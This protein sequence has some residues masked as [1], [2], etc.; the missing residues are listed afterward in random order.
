MPRLHIARISLL[1][2]L[3][4]LLPLP[5]IDDLTRDSL[6]S[7]LYAD[8]FRKAGHE[9][10][11]KVINTL[12][13]NRGNMLLG[14]LVGLTFGLI[15]KAFKTMLY[16]LTVKEM[17]DW[18]HEAAVR[19]EMVNHA[20]SRGL[21]PTHAEEVRTA[22]DLA[23]K[24]HGHSPVIRLLKGGKRQGW[25]ADGKNPELKLV[26]SLLKAGD[27]ASTLRDFSSRL[28]KFAH[29]L[30]TKERTAEPTAEPTVE[31]T[32][33]PTTDTPSDPPIDLCATPTN[34]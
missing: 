14:C 18:A 27:S 26:S 1:V 12:S 17:V 23:W 2:G 20:L 21:L 19:A 30:I 5:L 9:P 7:G 32:V 16:F 10:N 6:M 3:C 24:H 31:P 33:E 28:D 29:P 8:I 4:P 22:M 15:K 25:E 13:A 11:A 34:P